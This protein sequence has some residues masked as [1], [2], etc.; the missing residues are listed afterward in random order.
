MIILFLLVLLTAWIIWDNNRVA[1]RNY[2]L[3]VPEVKSSISIGLLSDIHDLSLS[4]DVYEALENV[5]IIFITGDM[6]DEYLEVAEDNI[7]KLAA[8]APVYFV[9]GNHEMMSAKYLNFKRYAKSC[10]V[11]VLENETTSYKDVSISG[12][13]EERRY[14]ISELKGEG[15][16]KILLTHHPE[17]IDRYENFDLVFA[18]HAHGG[19]VR[20]PFIGGLFAPGQGFFPKYTKGIYK[21]NNT[22]MIVSCGYGGLRPRINNPSEV[23]IVHIN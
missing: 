2:Y 9:S 8:I 7:Q 17:N 3:T 21:Q 12:L 13:C 14:E 22:T 6:I 4:N 5:D 1:V 18:G 10:G 16:Y 11:R 19:Q 20:I 15:N 23:C